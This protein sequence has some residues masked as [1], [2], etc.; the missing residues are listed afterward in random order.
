MRIVMRAILVWQNYALAFLYYDADTTIHHT[1]KRPHNY[2][3]D[4]TYQVLRGFL[5]GKL[6]RFKSWY[7]ASSVCDIIFVLPCTSVFCFHVR[8]RLWQK[9]AFHLF[10]VYYGDHTDTRHHPPAPRPTP[11]SCARAATMCSIE[12]VFCVPH[13]LGGYDAGCLELCSKTK[14]KD[15]WRVMKAVHVLMFDILS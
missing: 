5:F 6:F 1:D 2:N 10:L 13:G 11:L 15:A 7:F 3:M 14:K 9:R 4:S 12:L 8:V